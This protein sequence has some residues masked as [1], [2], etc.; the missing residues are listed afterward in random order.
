MGFKTC[1]KQ[2]MEL[3]QHKTCCNKAWDLVLKQFAYFMSHFLL[4]YIAIRYKLMYIIYFNFNYSHQ[5]RY[6]HYFLVLCLSKKQDKEDQ[7]NWCNQQNICPNNRIHGSSL[8]T[9]NSSS[10]K[11]WSIWISMQHVV[12]FEIIVC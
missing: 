4:W 1:R 7:K 3:R 12:F 6:T 10:E 2:I 8:S 9:N 11:W 5:C